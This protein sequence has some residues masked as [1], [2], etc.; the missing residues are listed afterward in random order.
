MKLDEKIVYAVKVL[1][2]EGIVV[3]DE[4]NSEYIEKTFRGQISSFGAAVTMGSLLSAVAFYSQKGG[5]STD[6]PKLMSAIYTIMKEELNKEG[7]SVPTEKSS[8]EYVI[9]NDTDTIKDKVIDAA[10]A[11]KLAMNV[12]E[13]RKVKKEVDI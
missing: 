3:I 11:L 1:K 2:D 9:G 5:A 13:L 12:Y 7:K 10:V 6:R 4:D 8:L